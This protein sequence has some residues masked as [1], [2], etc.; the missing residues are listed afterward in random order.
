M[1]S[2][3]L[4]DILQMLKERAEAIAANPPTLEERRAG[5]DAGDHAFEDLTGFTTEAVNANGV[6]A[7]WV[8]AG[9]ADPNRTILYLHG[10]G[11][12]VGS[13]ISHRGL[14]ASLTRSSKARVLNVGYRLAPEHRFP[15][16]VDD[17][18]EAYRWLLASGA[19][20]ANVVIGG[21][22]A[23]GGLAIATMVSIKDAGLPMPVRESVCRPGWTWRRW[24]SLTLPVRR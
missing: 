10:G 22:S 12:V 23:G 15:A 9:D 16:A 4:N 5:S 1:A 24:V 3:E 17:A 14:A 21:D 20:P 8:V 11:Y 6:P 18:L 2:P 7:E 19:D 13:I